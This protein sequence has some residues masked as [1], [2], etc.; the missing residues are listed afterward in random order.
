MTIKNMNKLL[1]NMK[2]YNEYPPIVKSYQI[3]TRDKS[4]RDILKTISGL[5][6]LLNT[7]D[8]YV[9]YCAEIEHAKNL[10]LNIYTWIA[11]Y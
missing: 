7:Y 8:K 9:N 11:G 1:Q 3:S 4:P 2:K 10:L 5:L 6:E